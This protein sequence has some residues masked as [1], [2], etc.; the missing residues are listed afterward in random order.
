[1]KKI[2]LAGLITI[3]GLTL[4]LNIKASTLNTKTSP[5]VATI[6]DFSGLVVIKRADPGS[7]W[8]QARLYT[9]L[10]KNDTIK[11]QNNSSAE[12][13][14][15]D[16]SIFRIEHNTEL[17]LQNLEYSKESKKQNFIMKLFSGILLTNAEKTGNP[18]SQIAIHTP[19][20]VLS[21]RGTEFVVDI[22]DENT[23]NVGVLSG[24]VSAR[25]YSQDNQLSKEE[26]MVKVDQ[27]TQI[28]KFQPPLKPYALRERILRHKELL[29]KLRERRIHI[30]ANWKNIVAN[31]T[32]IRQKL[33]KRI[34][35]NP[36]LNSPE[37]R[38]NI[39]ERIQQRN[40][41]QIQNRK[42]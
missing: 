24:Y 34:E 23:T 25:S 17:C 30:R 18:E 10:E 12:I 7:K 6:T 21:V 3:F 1:M 27:E 16:G 35:A 41:K 5:A 20:A 22:E 8:V 11:T 36:Q 13:T 38:E 33:R 19:T 31:R 2:K 40:K 39:K 15:E 37:Q 42:R 14:L 4:G 28:K 9:P 26:T 32:K 29:L